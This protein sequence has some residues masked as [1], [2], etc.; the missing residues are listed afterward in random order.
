MQPV[1]NFA[2]DSNSIF[3]LDILD[4]SPS[5]QGSVEETRRDA[6]IATP[7][8]ATTTLLAH[9]DPDDLRSTTIALTHA[10]IRPRAPRDNIDGHCHSEAALV[11]KQ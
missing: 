6:L 9:V 5:F 4:Q 8:A 3:V 7:S 2:E 11:R 10:E 1:A